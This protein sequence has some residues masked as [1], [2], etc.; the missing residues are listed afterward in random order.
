MYGKI[1]SIPV[2]IHEIVTL[3]TIFLEKK[4]I[5]ALKYHWDFGWD[6]NLR[7]GV[8]YGLPRWC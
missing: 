3:F 2:V 1:H 8:T 5:L 4:Y 6:N 7:L